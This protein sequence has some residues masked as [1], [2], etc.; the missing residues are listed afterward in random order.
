[1]SL[2]LNLG[3]CIKVGPSWCLQNRVKSEKFLPPGR[4][5]DHVFICRRVICSGSLLEL[6]GNTSEK[7]RCL[8]QVQFWRW[9]LRRWSYTSRWSRGTEEVIQLLLHMQSSSQDHCKKP[10]SGLHT[11]IAWSLS[12]R[13]TAC[14]GE[15]FFRFLRT[16]W[17]VS[18]KK[19]IIVNFT[20]PVQ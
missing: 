7:S 5:K 6:S 12:W 19:L 2:N 18:Q 9:C 13:L 16:N 11:L 14:V 10:V 8:W 3:K 1:M 15:S 20:P 4:K 17:Y